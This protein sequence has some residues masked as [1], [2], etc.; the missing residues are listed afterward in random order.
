MAIADTFN[1][2]VPIVG[3]DDP[4][5]S[6]CVHTDCGDFYVSES[7]TIDEFGPKGMY[8]IVDHNQIHGGAERIFWLNP[9]R[10]VWIGPRS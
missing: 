4:N 1:Q 10:I 9:D 8:R 7:F 2:T 6:I 3:H 5:R